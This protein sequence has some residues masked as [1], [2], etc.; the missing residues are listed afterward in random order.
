MT[1]S[2]DGENGGDAVGAASEPAPDERSASAREAD[3]RLARMRAQLETAEAERSAR[4]NRPATPISTSPKGRSKGVWIF[5]GVCLVFFVAM[6]GFALTRPAVAG[7]VGF[8][9]LPEL[10]PLEEREPLP[11]WEMPEI[12]EAEAEEEPAP[13]GP[14]GPRRADPAA[15]SNAPNIDLARCGNDPLCGS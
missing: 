3:E 2:H 8:E 6:I 15:P 9:P 13:R 4:Q 7:F 5:G 14:R 10:D 12:P 11:A 1:R